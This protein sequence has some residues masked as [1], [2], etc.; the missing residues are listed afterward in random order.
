MHKWLSG[1]LSLALTPCFALAAPPTTAE[2]PPAGK[3]FLGVALE[4]TAK[5]AP[6]PGVV[7]HDVTAASPA[8]KAGLQKGDILLKIDSA[9]VKDPAAVV[10]IVQSHK[11]G[12]KLQIR[13][14][15]NDKEEMR[16]ITLGERPAADSFLPPRPFHFGPHLGILA[17]EL[18]PERKSEIGTSIDKG[19]IVREVQP[20]SPAAKA[21]LQAKDVITIINGTAVTKPEELREALAKAGA[22]TEVTMKV[23]RGEEAKEFKV[24][25]E[26]S[27]FGLSKEF[28]RSLEK[29]LAKR[30]EELRKMIR[31]FEED[32]SSK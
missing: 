27:P 15:R 6:K 21:G 8:A 13:F 26:N 11:I 5:D 19:V 32:D 30:L 3:A 1:L 31:E 14:M 17:Q 23:Q 7:V 12:D 29:D 20:D 22:G 16:E 2:K 24:K 4:A 10:Q 9:E 28:S 18:T 25:L